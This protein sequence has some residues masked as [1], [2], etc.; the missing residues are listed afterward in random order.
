[1]SDLAAKLGVTS[2]SRVL[3]VGPAP[4]DVLEQLGDPHRR[5]GTEPYD[6]IVAFCPDHASLVRHLQRCPGSLRSAGGLWLTWPKRA[7]G[8]TTDTGEAD[9]RSCGLA[10]GLVDN[11]IASISAIWSGLRFVRRV[12]DRV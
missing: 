1:V 5:A 3:V 8:V 10:T 2:G 6:V 7:S 12:A 9:V 11:K 4:E